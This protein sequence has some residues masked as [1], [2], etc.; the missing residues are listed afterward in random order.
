[1]NSSE[2]PD[3]ITLGGVTYIY[4]QRKGW[5]NKQNRKEVSD[6]ISDMLDNAVAQ[7]RKQNPDLQYHV[8]DTHEPTP[9]Q[10]KESKKPKQP[11][12]EKFVSPDP[13]NLGSNRYVHKPNVGWVNQKTRIKA[14]SHLEDYLDKAVSDR[15]SQTEGLPEEE[16]EQKRQGFLRRGAS[17]IKHI[18]VQ[19]SKNLAGNMA[20][21]FADRL[22]EEIP[23]AR[24]FLNP[25]LG[26]GRKGTMGGMFNYNGIGSILSPSSGNGR[27]GRD[28]SNVLNKIFTVLISINRNIG[29]GS[30]LGGFGP[31]GGSTLS[32]N[33]LSGVAGK[34]K[35]MFGGSALGRLAGGALSGVTNLAG[36]V[37]GNATGGSGEQKA[38]SIFDG[39]TVN[40]VVVD[41][42]NNALKKLSNIFGKGTGNGVGWLGAL[43]KMLT[44]VLGWFAEIT[45][46][47]ALASL[48][49]K[50]L[51]GAGTAIRD[52]I[53]GAKNFI[54]GAGEDLTAGV[55]RDAKGVLRNAKGQFASAESGIV[56]AAKPNVVSRLGKAAG[57]LVEKIPGAGAVKGAA[58]GMGK[59]ARFAKGLAKIPLLGPLLVGGI[60]MKQLYDIQSD[61]DSHKISE[62]EGHKKAVG[63]A[64]SAIGQLLGGA[65]GAELGAALGSVVPGLGTII[66]GAIGGIGGAFAG[67]YIGDVAADKLYDY[68]ADGKQSQ[69]NSSHN[70]IG[71]S[72]GASPN[73]SLPKMQGKAS[74]TPML[75]NAHSKMNASMRDHMSLGSQSSKNNIVN[76]PSTT[77]NNSSSTNVSQQTAGY[78]GSL[79]IGTVL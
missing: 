58:L 46:L 75:L 65:G 5:V 3:P 31:N 30:K 2:F 23:I 79:N 28:Y 78:R 37:F 12:K 77:I 45:G 4:D 16:P 27:G 64:G 38:G 69:E 63:V 48:V 11:P 73:R 19:G 26:I 1:M 54:T 8:F 20:L 34:A 72:G 24:H 62:Q 29:G 21:N 40:S 6:A 55:S 35:G 49:R 7:D 67:G 76:A 9:K 32:D 14:D 43:G 33:P 56:K 25:A 71:A 57:G 39:P 66:G 74:P 53:K 50:F 15:E 10:V 60:A 51:G 18:G 22:S 36:K 59:I 13:V 68:F 47:K 41:I 17:H 42:D 70:K 61:V 52:G 44:G